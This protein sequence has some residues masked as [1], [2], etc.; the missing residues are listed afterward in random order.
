MKSTW[1]TFISLSWLSL[2]LAAAAAT[3]QQEAAFISVWVVHSRSLDDHAAVIEACQRVMDKTSTLGEFLPVVKTLAAWHLLAA[4]KEADAVRLFESALTAD[5]APQPIERAADTMAKRWLTRLD[6]RKVDAALKAYYTEHVE[7]P[8]SLSP[9]L[10][11][12]PPSAPSKADR[13]GDPWGY[14]LGEFSRL[15]KIKSQRYTLYS[16]N[17]GNGLS[18]LKDVPF[19]AYSPKKS[20]T[21]LGRKTAQP[22]SVDLETVVD[23]KTERVIAL[24]GNL[25]GGI[26]FLRLSADGRFALLA[27]SECDYWIVA[28]SK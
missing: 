14:R 18:F 8:A 11:M 5:K 23:G 24:E 21:L 25:T 6:I 13:F 19:T 1:L 3:P 10:S 17:L 12:P 26:R 4:G 2:A 27:D 15:A 16:K 28:P 22:V 7:F 9:V 20:A